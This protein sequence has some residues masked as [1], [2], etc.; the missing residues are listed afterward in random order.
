MPNWGEGYLGIKGA[1]SRLGDELEKLSGKM[2]REQFLKWLGNNQN[3][4]KAEADIYDFASK[5]EGREKVPAD[6]LRELI[7]TPPEGQRYRDEYLGREV[8]PSVAD[9]R[10]AAQRQAYEAIEAIADNSPR[11]GLNTTDAERMAW[12]QRRIREEEPHR[13]AI[14]DSWINYP[15]ARDPEYASFQRLPGPF[16]NYNE[17]LTKWATQPAYGDATGGHFKINGDKP[18]YWRRQS[19]RELPDKSKALLIEEIQSDLERAVRDKEQ[20]M[21]PPGP[22]IKQIRKPLLGQGWPEYRVEQFLENNYEASVPYSPFLTE[23]GGAPGY[24][25]AAARQALYDAATRGLDAVTWTPG[26][27]KTQVNAQQLGGKQEAGNVLNYDSRMGKVMAKEA[28][29]LGVDGPR[30]VDMSDTP[31]LLTRPQRDARNI[32]REEYERF[33]EDIDSPLELFE[34]LANDRALAVP[35]AQNHRLFDTTLVP[36]EIVPDILNWQRSYQQMLPASGPQAPEDFIEDLF[37]KFQDIVHHWANTPDERLS[38]YPVHGLRL[39]PEARDKLLKEGFPLFK[40]GGV[41]T[42]EHQNYG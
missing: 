31:E 29:R 18:A 11:P 28:R 12:L 23:I 9:A 41:V 6:E 4:P 8:D 10:D 25:N 22:M 5:F 24:L 36:P 38:S 37:D 3:V 14:R 19:D 1:T 42:E 27:L 13:Q 16:E 15:E 2:T 26:R 34:R 20:T 33:R 30:M 17:V 40:K 35:S 7:Q 32:V 21:A 39:T